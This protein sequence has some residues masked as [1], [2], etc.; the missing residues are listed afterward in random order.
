[1]DFILELL[2]AKEHLGDEMETVRPA[3]IPKTLNH[4]IGADIAPVGREFGA[5]KKKIYKDRAGDLSRA[6]IIK[7]FVRTYLAQG[8]K[9]V[10][11]LREIKGMETF[12]VKQVAN[13]IY[14]MKKR[15]ELIHNVDTG[16]YTLAEKN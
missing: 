2:V 7:S 13:T 6:T 16:T 3:I 12:T 9:N 11:Q 4:E 5:P 14:G 15:G 8:A 1:M 10:A